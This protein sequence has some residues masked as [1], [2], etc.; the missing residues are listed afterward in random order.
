MK[1]KILDKV[2]EIKSSYSDVEVTRDYVL[3]IMKG[4]NAVMADTECYYE[5]SDEK[6]TEKVRS[7]V[8]DTLPNGYTVEEYDE[9]EVLY[10][11]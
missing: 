9:K 2:F 10:E 1:I 8:E 4:L 11:F 5:Y 6:Y 3:G 7:I